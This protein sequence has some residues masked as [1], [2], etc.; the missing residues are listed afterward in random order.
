MRRQALCQCV[1]V[2][3]RCDLVVG[4]V[5]RKQGTSNHSCIQDLKYYVKYSTELVK[6]VSY[7]SVQCMTD[8]EKML[9]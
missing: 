8:V 5:Q 4:G 7:L 3:A 1:P 2:Y 9:N 6:F